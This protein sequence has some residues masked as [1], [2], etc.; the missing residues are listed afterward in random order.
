VAGELREGW[1]NDPTGRHAERWYI[2]GRA[3]FRVRDGASESADPFTSSADGPAERLGSR[4]GWYTDPLGRHQ[5]RWFSAG[6]PRRLDAW[7]LQIKPDLGAAITDYEAVITNDALGVGNPN[8]VLQQPY[9]APD[10]NKMTSAAERLDRDPPAPVPAVNNTYQVFLADMANVGV[11]CAKATWY[12]M[13][14]DP[15]ADGLIQQA[16]IDCWNG[17]R[18]LVKTAAQLKKLGV[19]EVPQLS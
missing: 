3:T 16:G 8:L 14:A 17:W 15:S 11:E 9:L 18:E 1:Y 7:M 13:P 19:L 6:L 5:N 10:C 12:N 4:E 2:A